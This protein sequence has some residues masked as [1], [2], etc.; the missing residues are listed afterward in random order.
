MLRT[1]AESMLTWHCCLLLQVPETVSKAT[2]NVYKLTLLVSI[3]ST[4]DTAALEYVEKIHLPLP[5]GYHHNREVADSGEI[6]PHWIGNKDNVADIFT[7]PLGRVVFEALRKDM[8][9]VDRAEPCE[10]Q[11]EC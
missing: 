8:R 6:V 7:K 4:I 3:R 5:Q 10:P 2:F 9:V 11:R 1:K